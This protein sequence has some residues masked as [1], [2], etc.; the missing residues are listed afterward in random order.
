MGAAKTWVTLASSAARE[1][2]LA[3]IC[4]PATF[5]G[6]RFLPPTYLAFK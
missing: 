3:M 4:V 6:I 5:G 2:G 1:K